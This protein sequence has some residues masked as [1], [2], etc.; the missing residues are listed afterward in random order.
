MKH[1]CSDTAEGPLN[2][3]SGSERGEFGGLGS[4]GPVLQFASR[5]W[6]RFQPDPQRLPGGQRPGISPGGREAQGRQAE[7]L[8]VAPGRSEMLSF[9]PRSA[10]RVVFRGSEAGRPR[11]PGARALLE[12]AGRC[13]SR[14]TDARQGNG[15]LTFPDAPVHDLAS[16]FQICSPTENSRSEVRGLLLFSLTSTDTRCVSVARSCPTLRDP[17]DCSPPGSSVPR[18]LQARILEWVAMPFSRGSSRPR[19]GSQVSRTAG[20]CFTS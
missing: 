2:A 7:P 20:R 15:S 3:P 12:D 8:T 16:D 14:N 11:D 17:L 18:I 1:S 9:P 6:A 10:R 13:S 5:C 4:V 19:D